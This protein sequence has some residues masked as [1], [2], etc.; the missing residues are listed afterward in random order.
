MPIDAQC[1][2]AP[3]DSDLVWRT[4]DIVALVE[5]IGCLRKN[6]EAVR[7][8]ARYVELAAVL[9]TEFDGYMLAEHRA[10]HAHIDGDIENPPPQ[11]GYKL[12]LGIRELEMEAAQ[13]PYAG[14]RQ[15]I[16]NERPSYSRRRVALGLERFHKE[17][18]GIA[19]ATRLQDEYSGQRCFECLHALHALY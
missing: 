7:E 5:E 8:P 15:I 14:P 1:R 10:S 6:D 19:K 12:R 3:L 18:A 4:I 16:L 2:I 17:A 13:H 11:H 9:F